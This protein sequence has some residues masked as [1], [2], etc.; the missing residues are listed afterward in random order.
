MAWNCPK[1]HYSS[2]GTINVSFPVDNH[3]LP[4][5]PG[6]T[7]PVEA[8]KTELCPICGDACEKISEEDYSLLMSQLLSGK[9][10]KVN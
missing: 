10:H 2:S 3:G 5:G 9:T 7:T 4:T 8:K 6:T 1:G